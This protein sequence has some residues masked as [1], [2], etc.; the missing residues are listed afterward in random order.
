MPHPLPKQGLGTNYA[1]LYSGHVLSVAHNKDSFNSIASE[2]S[3][4]LG[5]LSQLLRG[6]KRRGF[7]Y[8]DEGL[9]QIGVK[10]LASTLPQFLQRLLIGQGIAIRSG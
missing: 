4:S 3:S 1:Y 8:R 6:N 5:F 2:F 7:G 9:D 10:L